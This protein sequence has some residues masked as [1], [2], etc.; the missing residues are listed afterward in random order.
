V[1]GIDSDDYTYDFTQVRSVSFDVSLGS[2]A[3]KAP[4]QIFGFN[5]VSYDENGS[6]VIA[7]GALHSVEADAKGSFNCKLDVPYGVKTVYLVTRS[8]STPSVVEAKVNDDKVIYYNLG[9]TI[10]PSS[11]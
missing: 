1:P 5:P 11:K 6:V 3:A 9:I 7:D 10:N 2:V 4:V 8:S